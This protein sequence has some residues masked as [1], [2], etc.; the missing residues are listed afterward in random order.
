MLHARREGAFKHTYD[1]TGAD[2]TLIT[3]WN[4][5]TW[6]SKGEFT[7][8]GTQYA[9]HATGWTQQRAELVDGSG[10]QVAVADRVGRKHWTIST[11]RGEF[12][13]RRPSVWRGD[14]VLEVDGEQVGSIR[15]LGFWRTTAEADLP[16]LPPPVE[17]F[18][19][20]V[21]LMLWERN[22]TAAATAAS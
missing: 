7:L 18:A 17:V 19:L 14:Q 8:D 4:P 2:G 15:R 5:S 13:F 21:V 12:T 11:D 20:V 16:G 6:R 10:R 22:D 1:I 3:T 9:V